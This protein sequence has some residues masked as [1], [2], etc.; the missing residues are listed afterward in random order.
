MG[1]FVLKLPVGFLLDLFWAGCI[2]GGLLSVVG[3]L[4]D[5][6][7]GCC[8]SG[9]GWDLFLTLELPTLGLV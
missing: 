5:Y 8:G 3:C 9:F 4:R 2:L 7:S 6:R 1:D